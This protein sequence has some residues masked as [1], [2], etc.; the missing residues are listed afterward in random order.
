MGKRSSKVIALVLAGMSAAY[1]MPASAKVIELSEKEGDF[2]NAIAFN[3]GKYIYDGYKDDNDSGIYYN[4]GKTDIKLEDIDDWDN[5]KKYSNKYVVDDDEGYK[6]NLEDGTYEDDY[7]GE[8]DNKDTISSKLKT[9]LSKTNRYGKDVN[10][11]QVE[12]IN[13]NTFS[14]DIWYS[15]VAQSS[16]S[17]DG[18]VFDENIDQNELYVQILKIFSSKTQLRIGDKE[19]VVNGNS[20][21]DIEALIK[22]IKCANFTKY[23]VSNIDKIKI[24]NGEKSEAYGITFSIKARSGY[25]LPNKENFEE[26]KYYDGSQWIAMNSSEISVKTQDDIIAEQ[27]KSK[28]KIEINAFYDDITICGKTFSPAWGTKLVESLEKEIKS[29]TFDGYTVISTVAEQSE[30]DNNSG[31]LTIILGSKEEL[32]EVPDNL[33]LFAGNK[34]DWQMN[35]SLVSSEGTETPDEDTDDKD[36]IKSK[37]KIEINAFYNDITI[38]GK[39]FSP[40]WG[41]KLVESLEEEI[42]AAK[43]DG[44]TV[45]AT[46]SEQSETDNNSGKLTIILGAKEELNEVPGDLILFAGNKPD[47]EMS[48]LLVKDEADDL[49]SSDD[50]KQTTGSGVVVESI[51][52]DAKLSGEDKSEG[53]AT[54]YGYYNED[55]TYMDC[56]EI[57]NLTIYNGTRI[58]KFDKFNTSKDVDGFKMKIGLPEFV[59][60][61]GQDDN[62]IYS[63]I[64]VS[65]LG[66]K[67]ESDNS[68]IN[69]PI[70]YVQKISKAS[71]GKVDGANLPSSVE[72]FQLDNRGWDGGDN[73]SYTAAY[74]RIIDAYLNDP[75]SVKITCIDGE[76]YFGALENNKA[77][78][79]RVKLKRNAKGLLEDG[80]EVRE[81]MVSVDTSNETDD[82]PFDW[83]VDKNGNLWSIY[84]GKIQKS[85]QGSEFQDVYKV[86]RTMDR[87]DVY[88]ENNLI[89]W[90]TDTGIYTTVQ[91]GEIATNNVTKTGW[92]SVEGNWYLYD[93]SGKITTGWHVVNNSNWYYFNDEGIMQKGWLQLNGKTYYLSNSGI[94]KKGWVKIDNKWYYFNQSGE[95]Q[96]N[97]TIDGYI[98]NEN[99]EWIY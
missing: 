97:I 73:W 11:K 48:A 20:E 15:Y 37:I 14:N 8:E 42:K 69:E 36:E 5:F 32:N 12:N 71:N 51:A 9:K 13:N 78:N 70:Y 80:T 93:I 91:E 29:A 2:S 67:K 44:Y 59:A 84:K 86:D 45:I 98:L 10:V 95:K 57:A 38:C 92:Q 16:D 4:N 40:A 96:I 19:F 31:K 24:E 3:N 23:T 33:I 65:I 52:N 39:T 7:I 1:T 25:T 27:V 56:S 87:L 74:T 94:M 68:D 82:E 79:V 81:K 50:S 60:T 41:T 22:Q 76:I 30:A 46:V 55:G 72:S 99:G 54:Y 77:V 64:K 62:Y 49:I 61:L 88:D 90:S 75:E 28:I 66:A 34:P 47:W 85:S 6:I 43:F 18:S 53:L 35:A 83:T 26:I 63:L 89:A 17:Y 21:E 58:V